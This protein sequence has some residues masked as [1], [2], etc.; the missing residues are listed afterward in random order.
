MPTRYLVGGPFNSGKSTYVLSLVRRLESGLGRT[1]I[2]IELDVWSCS[3]PAFEGKVTF[4]DRPKRSGLDWD[5]KTP[6]DERL[7]EFNTAPADIVFGDLPGG[8]I[9]A[10]I[11]YMVANAEADGAIMVSRTL[12]GLWSWREAFETR[13]VPVVLECL[14][15]QGHPPLMLRDMDRKIDPTHPDVASFVER[16]IDA[17]GK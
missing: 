13:G 16:L 5:W 6:L 8:K 2:A 15:V 11:D 4:E 9:D 3:Y 10:A 7:E 12:D 14:S 17:E 1:A